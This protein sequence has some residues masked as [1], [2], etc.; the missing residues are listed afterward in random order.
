MAASKNGQGHI[1]YSEAAIPVWLLAFLVPKKG[2]PGDAGMHL[3]GVG[4][5]LCQVAVE[6]AHRNSGMLFWGHAYGSA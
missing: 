4:R 5:L 2:H 6:V 3:A 1:V